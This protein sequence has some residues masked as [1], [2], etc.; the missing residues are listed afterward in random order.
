MPLPAVL[1]RLVLA[2][3]KRWAPK[4]VG[5]GLAALG[6]IEAADLAR[7]AWR[8][9]FGANTEEARAG[10]LAPEEAPAELL[11]FL[12]GGERDELYDDTIEEEE[13]LRQLER[14]E[15]RDPAADLSVQI[16]GR[17]R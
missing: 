10:A 1:V 13:L 14:A 4:A 6:V 3:L 5:A 2:A 16:L 11:E 8:S 17:C 9:I 12:R 15:R 7:K